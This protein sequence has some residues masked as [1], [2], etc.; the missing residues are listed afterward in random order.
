[1]RWQKLF[2]DLEAQFAEAA[3]AAELAES[4]SRARAEAGTVTLSERLAGAVG[5]AVRLR[6]R[7][8]GSVAGVIEDV[9]PDWLLLSG[10]QGR[11]L[12][13]ATDAVTLVS[14]LVRRTAVPEGERPR[15]RTDL[16]RALRGLV[17][18]R[19]EVSLTL[20]DGGTISGTL[21][22]VGADHVELAEHAAGEPRR[23]AAV[24]AV[25]TVP[26]RALAV[27]TRSVE[28]IG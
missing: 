18:D 26:L 19:S 1:M 2:A 22:R 27:V 8:A 14:D 20:E 28:P 11:E 9:G 16:R 13:V 21:D 23:A 6:C 17:R 10:A 12:L 3:S 15:V 25:H 4:A 7:G 5:Q 24:R